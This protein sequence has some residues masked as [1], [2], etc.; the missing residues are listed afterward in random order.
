[1]K[2]HYKTRTDINGNTY[3][4]NI[5]TQKMKYDT[6]WSGSWCITVTRKEMRFLK[7][8]AKQEG[9]QEEK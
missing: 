5:D 1:M 3:Y 4:L 6:F 7:E 9:Y 8:Q 2:L